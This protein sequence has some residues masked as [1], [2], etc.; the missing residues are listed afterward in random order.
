MSS[1]RKL[2]VFVS[3]SHDDEPKWLERIQK[4]LAPLARDGQL[5]LWND[6]RI[7]SGQRWRDEIK[8]ALAYA[9]VAV[10][11]ISANFYASDFIDKNELP[12]LLEAAE[13]ERGLVIL[14]IH[15]NYSD[16][17]NDPRLSRYQTVNRPNRPIKALRSTADQEKVFRD[18]AREI[19]KLVPPARP[20]PPPIPAEYLAW[21]EQR[22]ASV[23]LL[24]QDIKQ[25][26]AF[27]LSHVY[28]PALTRPELA[29]AIPTTGERGG[30]EESVMW[31]PELKERR[32][33]TLLQR[34]DQESL[35]V[36][37]PAGA[38]KST[39]CRWV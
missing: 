15:I 33:V 37:A 28:V 23:E 1:D 25:S 3:Y 34:I 29:A 21:L 5:D 35:Y 2:N 39:V 7:D 18:L 17:E 14:G 19:R 30:P 6:T 13:S 36:P 24:G 27:K 9:D 10:L 16:F 8:A 22:C 20:G 26:H 12:P 11:L 31:L 38:G 4:H 32:A